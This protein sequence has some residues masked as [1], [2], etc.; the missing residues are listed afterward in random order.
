MTSQEMKQRFLLLYDKVT[1]LAA[2]GYIDSEIS[3]FLTKSQDRITKRYYNHKGN[4][5]KD[6][7]EETEKRRKDLSEL[8]RGPRDNSGNLLTSSSSSQS[9]VVDVNGEFFDLP[10]DF[11]YAISERIKVKDSTDRCLADGALVNVKPITHDEYTANIDNPFKNPSNSLAWRMDFSRETA[12]D[13]NIKRHEI[14]T[15]GNYKVDEYLL[16]YIKRPREIDIDGSL[17]GSVQDSELD[18]S[19]HEEIVDEAVMIA[20]GITNPN[21]YQIK[22]SETQK[23]E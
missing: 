11:L 14:I 19:I 12:G 16:R 6:G 15:N 17:T 18:E 2:P 8:I 23:S 22:M 21:E 10:E 5:Y 3:I 20:T 1:N 13:G 7:F 9:A 4:K